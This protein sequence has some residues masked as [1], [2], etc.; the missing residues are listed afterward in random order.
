MGGLSKHFY[1]ERETSVKLRSDFYFY[2]IVTDA[3]TNNLGVST[4]AVIPLVVCMNAV[5]SVLA[6]IELYR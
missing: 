2:M 6:D 5:D 3:A 1:H 4:I